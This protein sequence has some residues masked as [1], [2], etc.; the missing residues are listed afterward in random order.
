MVFLNHLLQSIIYFWCRKV[1]IITICILVRR[2][3]KDL[4]NQLLHSLNAIEHSLHPQRIYCTSKQ[5]ADRFLLLLR[6]LKG[7]RPSLICCVVKSDVS[8]TLI[9]VLIN[10]SGICSWIMHAIHTRRPN[11]ARAALLLL[12][13]LC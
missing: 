5:I 13:L 12:F 9:S 2:S 6:P 3:Q 8:L 7:V 10:T 4:Q 11:N 1:K